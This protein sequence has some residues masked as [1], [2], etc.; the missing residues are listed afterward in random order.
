MKINQVIKKELERV[1]PFPSYTEDKCNLLTCGICICHGLYTY[2]V[3]KTNRWVIKDCGID[4][5]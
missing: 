4:D 5:L 1:S 2:K 3:K